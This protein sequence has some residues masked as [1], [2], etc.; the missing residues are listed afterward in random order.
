MIGHHLEVSLASCDHPMWIIW[1]RDRQHQLYGVV[2]VNPN[3]TP[4]PQPPPL[5]P[6]APMTSPALLD[7]PSPD[8]VLPPPPPLAPPHVLPLVT[9]FSAEPYPLPFFFLDV[10]PLPPSL[11]NS[12]ARPLSPTT[13]VCSLADWG[14]E[15]G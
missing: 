9:S 8:L 13:R 12:S 5:A 14:G 1:G 11:L 6:P 3:Y 10:A 4:P 15:A 7:P 2:R